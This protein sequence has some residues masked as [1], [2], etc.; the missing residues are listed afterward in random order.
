[1]ATYTLT[2]T[3]KEIDGA[4]QAV[5]NADT[6]PQSNSSNMVTS[7]GVKDYVD[8]KVSSIPNGFTPTSYAG[9]ESVTFPN[10]LIMKFGSVTGGNGTVVTY[11]S[12]FPNAV[13]SVVATDR[14][15]YSDTYGNA[16]FVTESTTTSFKILSGRSVSSAGP[17]YWQAIGY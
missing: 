16:T 14:S 13:L 12:Q 4:V 3:A 1:M 15:A 10:G 6:A 7:G 17:F 5:T 9:E 8:T 2:N 11:G